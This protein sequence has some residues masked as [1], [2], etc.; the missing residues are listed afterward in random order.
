MRFWIHFADCYGSATGIH[1]I[2]NNDKAFTVAFCALQSPI[3]T[4]DPGTTPPPKTRFNSANS[5]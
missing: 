2:V 5:V 1:Q 3:K 4:K